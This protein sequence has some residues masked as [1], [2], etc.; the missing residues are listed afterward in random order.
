MSALLCRECSRDISTSSD[1][2]ACPHCGA[3]T[4][5]LTARQMQLRAEIEAATEARQFHTREFQKI[6]GI[7]AF[8]R[9]KELEHHSIKE[10]EMIYRIQ[11]LEKEYDNSFGNS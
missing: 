7:S 6:R 8:F 5:W 11:E 10:S 2:N 3:P 1:G 9:R 4:P